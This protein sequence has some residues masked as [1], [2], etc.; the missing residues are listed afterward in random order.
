[1]FGFRLGCRHMWKEDSRFWLIDKRLREKTGVLIILK[2]VLCGDVK[3][4]RID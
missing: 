2:C 3:E 4:K 1:M